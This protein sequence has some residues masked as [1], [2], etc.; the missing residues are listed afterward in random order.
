MLAFHSSS[1]VEEGPIHYQMF[2]Q[3]T[4]IS[5]TYAEVPDTSIAWRQSLP[6]WKLLVKNI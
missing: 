4:L 5:C 3:S 1:N 2:I 6:W